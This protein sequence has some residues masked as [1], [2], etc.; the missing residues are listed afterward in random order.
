METN[1]TLL[2]W[3]VVLP[4]VG[5]A[6]IGLLNRRLSRPVTGILASTTVGV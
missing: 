3:I 1:E 2:R 5:S 4:L 6:T